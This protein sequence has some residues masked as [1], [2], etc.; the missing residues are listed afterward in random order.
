MVH[1]AYQMV[2][3]SVNGGRRPTA[4]ER[5]LDAATAY[6]A[7]HGL[8]DRSLRELATGMGTSHRMLIYHFASKEG[9]MRAIVED[10]ESQQRA[11]FA[12][13]I[14]DLTLPPQAAAL[15]FW[16]RLADPSLANNV[17]LFF[18]LYGQALQGRPGT[19]GFLDRIVDAWVEPLTAYGINRGLPPKTAR[20]DA[21]LGVAVTRGLLL[22]LVATGDRAGVDEAY[23]RYVQLYEATSGRAPRLPL[24]L[25]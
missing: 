19:E 22:D 10:V 17:R 7:A 14:A 25:Y 20:A 8:H 16:E 21:R 6:V 23:Q 12:R 24:P 5:L 2:H 13:F 18:E 15:A 11:F 3:A 9:L 1:L 4:R